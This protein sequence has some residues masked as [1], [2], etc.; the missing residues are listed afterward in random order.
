MNLRSF[1]IINTE[2]KTLLE[3]ALVD[4]SVI[5]NKSIITMLYSFNYL[6]I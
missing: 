4:I 1:M 3:S 2:F 6:F 5:D